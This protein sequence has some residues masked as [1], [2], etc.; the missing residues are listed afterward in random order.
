MSRRFL[1]MQNYDLLIERIA[2]SAGIEKEEVE[3]KVEAK[4]AK[5]SGLISKEGAAQIIAAELG[6]NFEDDGEIIIFFFYHLIIYI[7]CF[8]WRSTYFGSSLK[9]CNLFVGIE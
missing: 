2:T 8:S 9:F 5:L 3:R 7:G 6:I 1:F 4:K